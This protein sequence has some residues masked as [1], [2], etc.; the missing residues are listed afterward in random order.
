MSL[1][2]LESCQDLQVLQKDFVYKRLK[3]LWKELEELTETD[4]TG[5]V[6]LEM[7]VCESLQVDRLELLQQRLVFR[8]HL[9]CACLIQC[10]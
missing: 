6:H 2:F 7:R 4:A 9:R 3:L 5:G 1:L 10:H 8:Q